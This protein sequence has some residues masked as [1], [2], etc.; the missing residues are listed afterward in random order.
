MNERAARA[1]LTQI[2]E[3]GNTTVGAM[4]RINGAAETL[5]LLWHGPD[6]KEQYRPRMRFGLDEEAI[7]AWLHTVQERNQ[8]TFL[9]PGDADWVHSLDD[10]EDTAPY[11]L[12]VRGQVSALQSLNGAR[13]AGIVGARAATSY[14]EH[15]TREITGDLVQRK[16][17]IV[18]GMAYGIDGA[19]HRTALEAGGVTVA[20]VAGGVDRPYPAGHLD[21]AERIMRS[22]AMV[23]EVPPQSTPTKWRFLA[24][25]RLI[26]AASEVTVVV[27]AGFRSGSLNTASH[28]A[29][30]QRPLAAVPG[31]ITSPASAG[32]HRL[33]QEGTAKLVTCAEDVLVVMGLE[34]PRTQVQLP[35]PIGGW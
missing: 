22:G 17:T 31:P 8:T 5:E 11:G 14:G 26:A 30:L 35:A 9:M 28:A 13:S 15:I 27:E 6:F 10:L 3:P 29:S 23:A 18:S 20:F 12:W 16:F 21:L 7:T 34:D 19:A 1:Y 32:C 2:T 25:N 33:I 4:V 24:R